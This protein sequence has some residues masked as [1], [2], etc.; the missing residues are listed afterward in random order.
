MLGLQRLVRRMRVVRAGR[1][2]APCRPSALSPP[3]RAACRA[4]PGAAPS[5]HR[6]MIHA[7]EQHRPDVKVEREDGGK[8]QDQRDPDIPVLFDE[9]AVTTKLV[10]HY[11][12]SPRDE[13]CHDGSA[14]ERSEHHCPVR[15]GHRRRKLPSLRQRHSDPGTGAGR[16]HHP[17]HPRRSRGCGCPGRRFRP[18]APSRGA[19][20]PPRQTSTRSSR[21]SPN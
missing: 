14:H 21:S 8:A 13:R 3:A 4:S 6:E 15:R 10:R 9:T 20:R 2:C 1:S 19:L 16:Y 17:E 7:A 12:W 11:G 5:R 18:W